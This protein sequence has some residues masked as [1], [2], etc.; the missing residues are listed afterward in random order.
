MTLRN[1]DRFITSYNRLDKIMR[2]IADTQEHLSFFRLIDYAKKKN[3]V[4]RRYEADL[5]E[6]GDLRNA[7]VHHRTTM[8][9]AIAEP[10]E[11]VVAK[12]EEIEEALSKPV[13]V[14]NMFSGEVT[15][16]QETDSL[17][18]ALQ[19][20]KDKKYNQF[21]VYNGDKFKGLITPVGITM[22]MASEVESKSFSRKKATLGE[23]LKHESNRENHRF[24]EAEMSVYEALEVFKS[25]IGRG[26]RLEALLITKDGKLSNQL[27]GI[28]TPM[29]M[30]KI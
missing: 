24:V 28:V 27:I 7:I 29:S 2:D 30:M 3:A 17:S 16:F 20:I 21:P 4:L 8:E 9:Y 6:Y 15:T 22:W 19:V 18:Y 13:T 26:K 5:R 11:E 1:S 10:H 12:M 23:I 14:G 25:A